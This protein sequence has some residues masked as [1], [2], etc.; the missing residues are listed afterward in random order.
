MTTLFWTGNDEINDVYG[1]LHPNSGVYRY[2]MHQARK[3]MGLFR[4]QCDLESILSYSVSSIY[5][6]IFRK[7][8]EKDE[9]VTERDFGFIHV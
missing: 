1:V 7:V 3:S 5:V 8:Q 6:Y 9:C 4:G 2:A